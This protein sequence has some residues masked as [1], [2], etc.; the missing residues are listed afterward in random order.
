MSSLTVAIPALNEERNLPPTVATVLSAAA[1]APGL[2]VEI[3]VIDDGSTD[4][5]AEVVTALAQ[6]HPN[7]RLLR[8]PHNMGLGASIRR[9]ISEAT[10][11]RFIIGPGDN[12][13]PLATLELLF[14]NADAA[15]I[16]M[17]Y[18]MNDEIRGRMRYLLSEMFRLIYTTLFD[19]YLR[20]LNGPAVY[21]VAKLRELRLHSTRFS[22]VAEINVKLLRQGPTFIELPGTRQTGNAGSTSASFRSLAETARVF[23]HLLMDVYL[24]DRQKYA[25]RPRRMVTGAPVR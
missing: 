25:K 19:L 5:T 12:D 1:K 23:F 4:R 24:M 21:P 6:Q 2:Q 13:M 20:Y 17:T 8:N 11:E 7:V 14:R 15:D 16:V 18:F 22:I 10:A 3:I 9:A